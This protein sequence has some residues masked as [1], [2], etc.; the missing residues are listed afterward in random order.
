MWLDYAGDFRNIPCEANVSRNIEL[1][2]R[3]TDL[4]KAHNVARSLAARTHDSER[5]RD[6]YF[7]VPVGRLKLRQRWS[8]DPSRYRCS[9]LG[10]REAWRDD[11]ARAS[12]LIWYHRSDEARARPSDYSLVEVAAGDALRELLAGALGIDVDVTKVRAIY[13]F[14]NVRIHLDQIAELGTFLEFEAMVD[15]DC[16]DSAAE[17]KIE[18]LRAAFEITDAEICSVSYSD[19]LRNRKATDIRQATMLADQRPA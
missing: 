8:I 14:Q 4:D 11:H 15:N 3:L 6:T 12:Q 13:L 19:L 7:R 1:K 5:Q 16:D 9:V 17:L 18:R 10:E 2:A